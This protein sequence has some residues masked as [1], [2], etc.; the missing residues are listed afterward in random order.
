MVQSN[1]SDKLSE[2][3]QADSELLS[4]SQKSEINRSQDRK[5]SSKINRE[6]SRRW[7]RLMIFIPL[8]GVVLLTVVTL[9]SY[10]HGYSVS[11]SYSL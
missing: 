6:M 3:K 5:Y 8:S 4:K 9:L 10:K 7:Q 1:S 11:M 2:R